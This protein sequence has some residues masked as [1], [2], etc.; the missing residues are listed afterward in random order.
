MIT[1]I[2]A[3]EIIKTKK[4][5]LLLGPRQVG[6][7]TL[8][9]GI[10]PDLEINL[11]DELEFLK[12]SGLPSAF[13]EAVESENYKSVYIDEIQRLPKLLN[14]IQAIVDKNKSIKFYLTGSSA[15]KLKRGGA[16]LLP[17]RLVNFNLGPLV[18]KELNYSMDVKRALEYGTLPD[19]YLLNSEKEKKLILRSYAANYLKEE[20]KAESLTRNLDSFARFFTEVTAMIAEFVDYTK[21]ASKSKISRHAIPR[22]FEILE[23]TLVGYRLFPFLHEGHSEDIIKHPKFYFFDNGVYNGLLGNYLASADRIG[24]LSEQLIF[25]QLLHSSWAND[26]DLKI[27]SFRTRA[28]IEVDFILEL[29]GEYYGIEVK[30]SPNLDHRELE[31]LKYFQNCFHPEGRKKSKLFVFHMGNTEKKYGEIWSLPWQKGLKTIGL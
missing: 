14:T 22:Y 27:F 19:P 16:N 21:L 31:G 6:K 17:G 9:S 1:R 10:K 2:I 4:S 12:Y 15:R 25:S 11:S 3:P 30:T 20:I 13:R 8:I 28:G 29:Q 24:K 7:T 5:V 18:A 23:D 26:V